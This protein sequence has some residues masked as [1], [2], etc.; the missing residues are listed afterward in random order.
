VLED[1]TSI[2][3][4]RRELFQAVELQHHLTNNSQLSPEDN[5]YRMQPTKIK[6]IQLMEDMATKEWSADTDTDND[7]QPTNFL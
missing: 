6:A 5:R 7:T 3:H 1:L 2:L 4:H